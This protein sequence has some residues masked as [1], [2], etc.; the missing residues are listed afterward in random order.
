MFQRVRVILFLLFVAFMGNAVCFA[1]S[2]VDD[3]LDITRT[4]NS[5]EQR[6]RQW[7]KPI[8]KIIDYFGESNQP[9]PSGHFN[10]RFIGGPH[11]SSEE[12]FGLG[13]AGSAQYRRRQPFAT[14]SLPPF[15]NMTLKIDVTTGQ[16][17]KIGLEGFH[18]F[19]S[20]KHRLNYDVYLFSFAD[21]FWGIGYEQNREDCNDTHYKRLQSQARV[22][23][24]WL[25]GRNIYLGPA[26]MFSYVHARHLDNKPI[27]AGLPMRTFNMGVGLSFIFDSRDIPTGPSKGL[28]IEL[29]Q[30]FHPRFL[31]NK[32]AFTSTELLASIYCPVWKGALVC[33]MVHGRFTYGNTPWDLLS[34]FGGS[35][36]MRGYYEGRYRDKCEADATIELR[37]KV[38]RR[39]GL[40]LW[41][42]AG[43]IAPDLKSFTM[44]HVLPNAGIGYRW[45]FKKGVNV[46]LDLGFGR[47]EKSVNFS[48]NEA[49]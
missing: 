39:N 1:D 41:V 5:T 4:E 42:G 28:R 22:N 7:P 13:L 11:Y 37:Q 47:G 14:D 43:S 49:F 17:Y 45:E 10:I 26:G 6:H 32:W 31:A 21:R 38:W 8:Q 35:H 2:L 16:M 48:L 25:V 44:R 20:G 30:M 27:A 40:V 33:P 34:T 24:E 3:T 15:S 46:R 36:Y 18:Y 29:L 12:G 9:D 23:F 19:P